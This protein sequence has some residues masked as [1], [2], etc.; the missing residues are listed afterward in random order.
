MLPVEVLTWRQSSKCLCWAQRLVHLVIAAGAVVVDCVVI[1]WTH[2]L[3]IE[4]LVVIVVESRAIVAW[5][6]FVWSGALF[7]KRERDKSF[8]KMQILKLLAL[9]NSLNH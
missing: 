8:Y 3:K 5:I 1:N 2:L 9:C 4:A 6:D 7:R